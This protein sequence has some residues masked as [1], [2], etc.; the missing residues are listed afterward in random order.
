MNTYSKKTLI[1]C[2][3]EDL[4]N[5]HIDA[6]N[7][8]KITPP[9]IKVDLLNDNLSVKEG[10]LLKINTKKFFINTYWEV[11]IKKLDSPYI[12]VDEAIKSPFKS[13]VHEHRFTQSKDGVILEDYIEFEMPFSFIGNC[14]AFLIKKDLNGMFSY[15]HEQTK[16]ILEK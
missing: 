3:I 6:N 9:N 13:W 1:K 4:F 2:K 12:L 16:M 14:F 10:V 7:L 15:R 11:K 5:F 8:K